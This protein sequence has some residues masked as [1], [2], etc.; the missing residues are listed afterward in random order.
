MSLINTQYAEN[1]FKTPIPEK[2]KKTKFE[3]KR[4]MDE[5]YENFKTVLQGRDVDITEK[6]KIIVTLLDNYKSTDVEISSRSRGL[7]LD[8]YTELL[9]TL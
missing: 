3:L 7:L 2:P 5:K 9:S 8:L 6:Q 1:T 4:E